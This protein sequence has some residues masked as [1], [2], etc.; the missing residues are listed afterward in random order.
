M[1]VRHNRFPYY[2]QTLF[3]VSITGKK[4]DASEEAM[5]VFFGTRYYIEYITLKV[6]LS[7]ILVSNLAQRKR[8]FCFFLKAA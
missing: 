3:N 4:S 8:T 5:L 7:C 1:S 6:Q 2:V